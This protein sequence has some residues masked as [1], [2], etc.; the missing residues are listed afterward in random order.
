MPKLVSKFLGVYTPDK[1]PAKGW[2]AALKSLSVILLFVILWLSLAHYG[3]LFYIY[4]TGS[5]GMKPLLIREIGT[6][7]G[8]SLL[9]AFLAWALASFFA[10][11]IPH[12]AWQYRLAFI[13][14]GGLAIVSW[15]A[16][17]FHG[18]GSFWADSLRIA[19]SVLGAFLGGLLATTRASGFFENNFPPSE[20]LQIDLLEKHQMVIGSGKLTSFAKRV[21]DVCLA[22]VGL[23]IFLPVGLL[24]VF[25]VWFENPGPVLFVKNSVGRGGLNFRQYKFRTMVYG[26]E[27]ATGPVLASE[28][29]GRTL[30]IGRL[31]RK[32]ALDELPQLFNI[33]VGEMSFVGPR[34]QRSVLVYG[35]LEKMPDYVE[36]HRVAPGLAGLAQVG[37]DYYLTP[38]QKLR[39]DRL[40]IQHASSGLDLKLLLLAVLIAFWFR[41]QRNW[42]GRLPRWMLHPRKNR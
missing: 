16:G 22:L 20:W 4:S 1:T 24:S 42:N 10:V 6:S 31:L 28:E 2:T 26:A 3:R 19:L 29:D 21:F 14:S 13:F 12:S 40:Y 37:G 23:I 11:L 34:P 32:T 35:Y 25:L 27:N 5:S 17:L 30:V 33:L 8:L 15:L 9:H 38:R 39:F 41:W 7:L 18:Y 36:R